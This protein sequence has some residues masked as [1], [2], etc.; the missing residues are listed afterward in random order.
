MRRSNYCQSIRYFYL[1]FIFVFTINVAQASSKWDG[2]DIVADIE[3]LAVTL[4]SLC[5]PNNKT[6]CIYHSWLSVTDVQ[7]G[8]MPR[9]ILVEWNTNSNSVSFLPGDAFQAFLKWD[10]RNKSYKAA[11]VASGKDLEKIVHVA[12]PSEV[13]IIITK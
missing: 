12:L 13:G 6:P 10:D 4:V 2:V 3:V 8:E 11:W 9:T 7:K 5:D 1:L